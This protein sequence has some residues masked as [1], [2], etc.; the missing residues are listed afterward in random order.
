MKTGT[1][2][3]IPVTKLLV[4][5]G[6]GGISPAGVALSAPGSRWRRPIAAM[7]RP[8]AACLIAGE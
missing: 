4:T 6:A 2:D 3:R 8:A 7:P 1:P 5:G